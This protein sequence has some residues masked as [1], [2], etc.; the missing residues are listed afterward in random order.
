MPKSLFLSATVLAIFASWMATSSVPQ[1]TEFVDSVPPEEF[2]VSSTNLDRQP[3]AEGLTAS[4]I[5]ASRKPFERLDRRE[6]RS[7]YNA[8]MYFCNEDR[9]DRACNAYVHHCGKPCQLLV[10]RSEVR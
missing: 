4:E 8:V 10:Q 1:S 9:D 5:L 2:M 7:L 6:R 3:S